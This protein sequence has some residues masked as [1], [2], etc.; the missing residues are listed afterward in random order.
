MTIQNG[1]SS[2][3]RIRQKTSFN[4]KSPENGYN[5]NRIVTQI[6]SQNILVFLSAGTIEASEGGTSEKY[7]G[8]VDDEE[9]KLHVVRDPEAFS[10]DSTQQKFSSVA[11][12]YRAHHKNVWCRFVWC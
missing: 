3:T 5:Q 9:V 10:S 4:I 12:F 2:L 11:S 7:P 6:K 8:Y 1:T